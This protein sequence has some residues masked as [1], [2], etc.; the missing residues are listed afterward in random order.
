MNAIDACDPG[1]RVEVRAALDGKAVLLEVID[2]GA[3]IPSE[4]RARVFDPFFTTKKRGQGTGLGLW[5]V[6]EL[7]RAHSADIQVLG[8]PGAGTTFQIKWPAA[9][10]DSGTLESAT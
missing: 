1:G 5:V 8:R 4:S 3:G 7:V 10:P 9:K 6:A 2:D